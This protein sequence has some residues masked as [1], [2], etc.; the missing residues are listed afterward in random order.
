MEIRT[1]TTKQQPQDI[2]AT[3]DVL[4]EYFSGMKVE[5]EIDAAD[6][7]VKYG[8]LLLCLSREE[9]EGF[10]IR[11]AFLIPA[12]FLEYSPLA[13][14]T[15]IVPRS[16][17]QGYIE[18]LQEEEEYTRDSMRHASLPCLFLK[19]DCTVRSLQA[20]LYA[21]TPILHLYLQLDDLV[22]VLHPQ[23]KSDRLKAILLGRLCEKSS[24]KRRDS[25]SPYRA[26]EAHKAID[27]CAINRLLKRLIKEEIEKAFHASHPGGAFDS[28]GRIECRYLIKIIK[29]GHLRELE[30]SDISSIIFSRNFQDCKFETLRRL[31]QL[32]EF[33]RAFGDHYPQLLTKLGSAMMDIFINECLRENVLI[34]TGSDSELSEE[35][36]LFRLREIRFPES[37]VI[38]D[39]DSDRRGGEL[40]LRLLNTTTGDLFN[41]CSDL[42]F[43]GCLLA[44]GPVRCVTEFLTTSRARIFNTSTPDACSNFSCFINDAYSNLFHFIDY[45]GISHQEA[46]EEIAIAH[47]DLFRILQRV[48]HSKIRLDREKWRLLIDIGDVDISFRERL[49][50]EGSTVALQ[51]QA[52]EPAIFIRREDR[53]ANERWSSL[54]LEKLRVRYRSVQLLRHAEVFLLCC[55]DI[56]DYLRGFRDIRVENGSFE[57]ACRS[58][59]PSERCYF[60]ISRRHLDMTLS[61]AVALVCGRY[62]ELLD[63]S[64][65]ESCL[66][67]AR[68]RDRDIFWRLLREEERGFKMIFPLTGR[69]L[70]VSSVLGGLEPLPLFL[71]RRKGEDLHCGHLKFSGFDPTIPLEMRGLEYLS[72]LTDTRIDLLRVPELS[73][74]THPFEIAD[75]KGSGMCIFRGTSI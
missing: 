33:V 19:R 51:L 69:C 22:A 40:I 32:P 61:A 63:D 7:T 11:R 9:D 71:L 47:S 49:K 38:P 20:L 44:G 1:D 34:R 54:L 70:T 27:Q 66:P 21:H 41:L 10:A 25:R 74:S 73:F 56:A 26:E 37:E 24:A 75:V 67:Q 5:R 6:V 12:C 64:P 57:R 35:I 31:C 23:T 4:S 28:A 65:E 42:D 72:D 46:S 48:D 36:N 50:V 52:S 14:L 53:T 17:L 15:R 45:D 8:D 43:E 13:R 60:D 16:L 29:S 30:A 3:G 59:L 68:N 58:A 2:N 55:D 18:L 39:G 62:Y